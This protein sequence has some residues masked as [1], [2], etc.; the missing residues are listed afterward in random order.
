[1][2]HEA[3]QRKAQPNH[4]EPLPPSLDAPAP[5]SVDSEDPSLLSGSQPALSQSPGDSSSSTDLPPT[6]R[7]SSRGSYSRTKVP[8]ADSHV[9]SRPANPISKSGSKVTAQGSTHRSEAALFSTEGVPSPGRAKT[10]DER[11]PPKPTETFHPGMSLG[12]DGRS[13][14]QR[15]A[16]IDR[17]IAPG[18]SVATGTTAT[19]GPDLPQIPSR[20]PSLT[21]SRKP[22]RRAFFPPPT[23]SSY[24]DP[25]ADTLLNPHTGLKH[26]RTSN[27]GRTGYDRKPPEWYVPPETDNRSKDEAYDHMAQQPLGDYYPPPSHVTLLPGDGPRPGIS[28]HVAR[29]NR[30]DV[31]PPSS[32]SHTFRS[33]PQGPQ[34]GWIGVPAHH[35]RANGEPLAIPPVPYPER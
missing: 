16:E 15:V 29:P 11:N 34:Q 2:S 22:G 1:M 14:A 30:R 25:L 4:V 12:E 35:P 24:Q 6:L 28:E 17:E 7:S 9:E 31:Y 20:P 10:K 33:G 23:G 13:L 27:D 26:S 18:L 32:P 8:I 3:K 19:E 21:P 5:L